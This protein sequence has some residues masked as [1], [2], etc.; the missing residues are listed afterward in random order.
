MSSRLISQIIQ[1][2][3]QS[4]LLVEVT[5]PEAAYYPARPL[6]SISYEDILQ[7][8]RV[9]KGQEPATRAEPARDLVR[10]A[11]DTIQEAEQRM[12]KALTVQAMVERAEAQAA[13]QGP[14]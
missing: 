4:Q 2:L 6:G 14:A 3:L 12:T 13:E 5:T 7:T 1:P 8:L 10:G 11:I 9:G